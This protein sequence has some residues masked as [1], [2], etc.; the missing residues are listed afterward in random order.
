MRIVLDS[1]VLVRAVV[2]PAGPA[3]AVFDLIEPPHVLVTSSAVL[4]DLGDA[5]RYPRLRRMHGLSDA[6]IDVAIKAV[7]ACAEI[8]PLGDESSI[9]SV[10][11]DRDDDFILATAVAAKADVLC[12]LDR[13]LR[14]EPVVD[15]C[16]ENGI[17]VLSDV[18]LLSQ[19]RMQ[20]RTLG[21]GNE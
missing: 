11:T 3:A 10:S 2:S 6:E 21:P 15:Y 17:T 5:L 9:P 7:H 18:E 14:A 13:H 19:L 16:R 8:A 12:T 1:N 20:T 4:N